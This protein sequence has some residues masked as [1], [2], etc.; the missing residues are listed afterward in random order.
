M[1]STILWNPDNHNRCSCLWMLNFLKAP[2]HCLSAIFN[3]KASLCQFT[4][5]VYPG[6]AL[7]ARTTRAARSDLIFHE[8][9]ILRPIDSTNEISCYMSSWNDRQPFKAIPP[10]G[11]KY[12]SYHLHMLPYVDRF[13]N[14][15]WGRNPKRNCTKKTDGHQPWIRRYWRRSKSKY[16]FEQSKLVVGQYY[17]R[18]FEALLWNI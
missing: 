18:R 10:E 12:S 16:L 13:L 14:R 7:Y 1:L 15:V 11:R 4:V 3:R 17:W 5:K 6:L 9:R 2:I 8:G